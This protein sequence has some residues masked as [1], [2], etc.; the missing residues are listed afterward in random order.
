MA[1][2]AASAS[3][4]RSTFVLLAFSAALLFGAT[5]AHAAEFHPFEYELD[6]TG[7]TAGQFSRIEDVAVHQSDGTVYVLDRNHHSIDKFDANGDP[8]NF[9]STGK[10]SLDIFATCPGASYYEYGSDG[11]AVDSSGTANDGTIYATGNGAGGVCAFNAAGEYL[12]RMSD[13]DYPEAGGACGATTDPLG[14]LWLVAGSML[15]YTAT[16]NPPTLVTITEPATACRAAVGNGGRIYLIN[17]YANIGAGEVERWSVIGPQQAIASPANGGL[18]LDPVTEHIYAGEGSQVNEFTSEGEKV[19][20][21]GN[22]APYTL[23]GKGT[24]GR[25]IGIAVRGS[26]GQVYIADAGTETLKVY[27]PS[28]TFPDLT[29][30][31][32]NT[33]RRTTASLSGNVQPVGGDVTACRF[34]WG[35]TSSYGHEAPCDQATPI[36]GPLDVSTGLTGL[37]PGTT[38]HYRLV[39][40]NA[41]GPNWGADQTFTTPFV[42]QVETAAASS[43]SRTGATL[44]GSLSP[45]GVDTHYY[46]E[47]GTDT[48]YGHAAPASP[49]TDAGSGNS[50]APA[51]TTISG[52]S[53]GTTYHYRLVASNTE[54]TEYGKDLSFHTVEAVAGAK[55][56]P[57]SEVAPQ[58]A[59]LNGELDPEGQAT[60]FYFEWGPTA[61]YGN[62][63]ATAPGAPVGPGTGSTPVTAPI[64]GLNPYTEYHYRLV[65]TNGIGTTHGDDEVLTTS[66]PALPAISGMDSKG[67]TATSASLS[68][69][70]NPGFGLTVYRF[71]YGRSTD[72][73]S[74]TSLYGPLEGD[75]SAH[76]VDVTVTG[77]APAT[78]YHYRVVAFNFTG[79]TEGP[80]RTF[81][82]PGP[83]EVGQALVSHVT[84]SS[85]HVETTINPVLAA[86]S[87]HVEYNGAATAQVP[88]GAVDNASHTASV[89]LT[90]LAPATAYRVRVVA[91][92][93]NGT[94]V[95]NEELFVTQALAPTSKPP[96]KCKKGQVKRKGRCVKK[97]KPAKRRQNRGG[98][99]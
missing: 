63:T 28:G 88:I 44:N 18:G 99:R 5:S 22:Q 17:Q 13:P 54:G 16:G 3:T 15:Q 45:D 67:V 52:L 95:G 21:I 37:T 29:T 20:Q 86:T 98:K 74:R 81:T 70:V 97:K 19:G 34:E 57:A 77:L 94:D 23:T 41:Q 9:S 33:V 46:F 90:G 38:Y 4:A 1:R 79:A 66:P 87:F 78:T 84:T 25:S 27:G 59:T 40:E 30:G 69:Q 75:G 26:T 56:L 49:G 43:V 82:T 55:T 93:A 53:F 8:Q 89:D 10:S 36:G 35:P 91:T 47:W 14:R 11:I 71:E 92:N 7:T 85:A 2:T 65:A 50:S 83:P 32:A 42:D 61:A 51:V 24:I 6:G 96:V 68:A 31:E 60:T 80:D 72:Y 39:A 64:E 76:P 62:V 48:S 58:R 73:E 12:W